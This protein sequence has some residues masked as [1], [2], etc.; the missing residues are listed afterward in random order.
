MREYQKNQCINNTV[1]PFIGLHSMAKTSSCNN[2]VKLAYCLRLFCIAVISVVF[3][4]GLIFAEDTDKSKVVAK[5]NG[6]EIFLSDVLFSTNQEIERA[7]ARGQRI[8][9]EI[10]NRVRKRWIEQLIRKELLLQ[11]AIAG[12]VT[13][14]DADIETDLASLQKQGISV[15]ADKLRKLIKSELMIKKLINNHIKSKVTLTDQEVENFYEAQKNKFK[16]PEQV[17]ARHILIRV[18]SSDSKEKREIAQLR[19]ES[20]LA[21]VKSGKKDFSEIAKKYSEG[22]TSSNGGDLGY[23]RRGQMAPAF[24]KVV[25]ALKTGE[26][27]DVVKTRFGYH[28]IK[29]ENKKEARIMTFAELKKSIRGNLMRQ[30]KNKEMAVWLKELKNKATIERVE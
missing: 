27:S 2:F 11:E 21:K 4:V 9:P 16:Q 28:I 8:T 7:K 30:R 6:K 20:I 10:E 17:R 22:P 18:K 13:I 24:D 29:V 26:I 5:V 15:S 25:F 12:N 1:Q 19:I 14:S 3:S 23:F